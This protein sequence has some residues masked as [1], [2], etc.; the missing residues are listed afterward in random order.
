MEK[1]T[2]SNFA[3]RIH[4]LPDERKRFRC[5]LSKD[6]ILLAKM[7]WQDARK[8]G[9]VPTLPSKFTACRMNENAFKL[10]YLNR[11]F[12]LQGW[13]GKID[14]KI[15]SFQLCRADSLPAG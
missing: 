12:I 8:N 13:N 4:C 9:L 2:R 10:P 14:K 11:D 6:F 1:R 3:E 7:K 5:P 15:N